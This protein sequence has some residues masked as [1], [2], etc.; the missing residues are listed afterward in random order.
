MK[1]I[2]RLI[3]GTIAIVAVVL[4]V[5]TVVVMNLDLNKH[6]DRI[7]QVVLDKTGRELQINGEI[8]ASLFP[9]IG[10]SLNDVTFANADGFTGEFFGKVTSSDL[11]VQVLPL[12]TG[13]INVK[14]I[15]FNGLELNLQRNADGKTNWDDLMATTAVVETD[16][17]TDDVVQ[18][19]EAGAP[20]VA[21]LSVGGVVIADAKV[22]WSDMQAG[23]DVALDQFN[24]TTGAISLSET[25]P[26]ETT[27]KVA[28]NSAG[29]ASDVSASGDINVNLAENI[30]QLT[31]LKLK[32][33]ATGTAL[34]MDSLSVALGG[35]LVTDLNSQTLDFSSMTGDVA[36][37]PLQGEVH[38]TN[39]IDAPSVF[40][41]LAGG[42]FD[43]AG[44]LDQLKVQLPETFDRTLLIDAGFSVK[45]QQF[46]D[47][48][49]VNNLVLSS[50]GIAIN[51]DFQITNL[52]R[53]AVVSGTLAT[54]AFNPGP[55]A[56]SFGVEPSD[57]AVLKNAQLSTS[58]RQSGQLLTLNDLKLVLDDFNLDGDIEI[59]DI[60][61]AMP[62]VKFALKGTEIDLDR[63]LPATE[64]GDGTAPADAE[65]TVAQAPTPLPVEL[66]RQLDI[67]GDIKMGKL[68]VAGVTVSDIALPLLAKDGRIELNEGKAQLYDGTLFSSI[69]LDAVSEEP[70]LTISTNLNG[71]QAE[72]LLEDI[73][74][75]S[76]PLS[77]T[78]IISADLLSRGV[79]LEDM[80]ARASGAITTRFTDGAVNGINLGREIRRGKALLGGE[81]LS[82][83]EPE[84][85]TDFT[86]L[87]VSAEIADGVLQSDDLA[88][89]SPLLR[90]SG[91]GTVDLP[92]EVVDYVLQIL[93]TATG[94]GQGGKE[95][96]DLNGLELPVPIR[97]SFSDLSVDFTG[98][99]VNGLK[100][101]LV[102]QLKA[103]KDA[104]L[105]Q[106]KTAVAAKLQAKEDE[107]KVRA[108]KERQAAEAKLELKKQE[109]AAKAEEK[110]AELKQKLAEEQSAVKDKLEKNLKKGLSN[111]LGN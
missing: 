42:R 87:S 69:A 19:V 7:Q 57:P 62:P 104:L 59:A 82:A 102:N 68:K 106:Q 58:I 109:L 51:G 98:V 67:S 97:G 63:Y 89:K 77:G 111:L 60:N 36:G 24:L 2:K 44:L 31:G 3:L 92:Q 34:P 30:Y 35:D 14:L 61:A 81:Q 76:A 54:D 32:T 91:A 74:Q 13:N 21:A 37:V 93:V 26:F 45:F 23:N 6:K 95:L 29:V 99:L 49:L 86:E 18:E 28:S 84:V 17:G 5:A 4:I 47:Q 64:E 101:D 15:E 66:L 16:S 90:L 52:A 38:V 27:F 25:F 73:L 94:E 110:K 56:K 71:I 20:V 96:A 9:W 8:S 108:E 79:T 39:M 55:W 40:G 103:K 105:N 11:K 1:L 22:R 33:T 41:E 10:F 48:L 80:L 50:S 75:D 46:D 83:V 43:A 107:L 70:L 53:S 72:P 78:A 85:K 100:A 88:F 65:P 12:L